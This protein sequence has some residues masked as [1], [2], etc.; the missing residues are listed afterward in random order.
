MLF[1]A[2][3]SGNHVKKYEGTEIGQKELALVFTR[4]IEGSHTWLIGLDGEQL[5]YTYTRILDLKP[6]AHKFAAVNHPWE[7]MRPGILPLGEHDSIWVLFFP[8]LALE[9]DYFYSVYILEADLKPGFT[10]VPVPLEHGTLDEP[11][12]QLCLAEEPHDSPTAR[13]NISGELRYPSSDAPKV[14]CSGPAPM[15]KRGDGSPSN[16]HRKE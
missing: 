8:L 10:Y 12:K 1:L 13:V 14:G 2:G 7:K 3:C 9:R 5:N 15:P 11:A 4:H 6:G 16:W